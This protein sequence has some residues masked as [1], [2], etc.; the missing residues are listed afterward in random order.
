MVAVYS[1]FEGFHTQEEQT[2][3]YEKL[4]NIGELTK[5]KDTELL[6]AMSSVNEL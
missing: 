2:V 5:N 1:D 6:I 3:Y 4:S